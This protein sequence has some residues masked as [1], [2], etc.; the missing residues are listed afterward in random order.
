M[1]L[2]DTYRNTVQRKQEEIAK[3]KNDYAKEQAKIA[4]L[5]KKIISAN[6][7]INR[8]KSSSTIKSKIN[9]IN[10]SNQSIADIEKKLADI[11]KKISQ[12][13]KELTTAR[14]NYENEEVKENKKR[15]EASRRLQQNNERQMQSVVASI[16]R[17]DENQQQMQNDINK[18]LAIPQKITVLFMASNPYG[19]TQLRVDE[20]ARA[21]QEKIR[22]SEYRDSVNFE[23]RWATRSSDIFQAINETNPTIIHFSG[24]GA[25]TGDLVL[26]NPDGSIKLVKKEAITQAMATVSE[27]IRLVV[28]NTCFSENQAKSVVANIEAAIGMAESISDD[29]ARIFAAQLYSAIGFGKSLSTAFNQAR[30]QLLLEGVEEENIPKLYTREDINVDEMILVQ[31]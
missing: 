16:K 22:L 15:L 4:P 1:A 25:D 10:R 20:E 18:L 11:N 23:S 12:K 27:T 14:K 3:L 8:S 29:A 13:E 26:Q 17:Q 21:I 9:E 19:T 6:D 30:A 28:F 2:L 24:H 7:T 31:P 5:Q